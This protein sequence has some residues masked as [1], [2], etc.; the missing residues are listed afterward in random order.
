MEREKTQEDR[1][2]RKGEFS[3]ER[4]HHRGDDN[5]G[6]RHQHRGDLRKDGARRDE[7]RG[8]RRGS[9]SHREGSPRDGIRGPRVP[10]EED[11]A[12]LCEQCAAIVNPAFVFKAKRSFLGRNWKK[13]FA[14]IQK[15]KG[16]KFGKDRS[17]KRSRSPN[18][19]AS[20][21]ANPSQAASPKVQVCDTMAGA[22]NQVSSV[23]CEAST[24]QRMTEAA[25]SLEKMFEE[26]NKNKTNEGKG[27]WYRQGNKGKKGKGYWNQQ[28]RS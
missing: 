10:I 28:W 18:V 26:Q 11:D 25:E 17:P 1:C 7:H 2:Q 27:D 12:V 16:R 21:P 19:G 8:Q 15:D 22:K 3:D 9:P 6:E 24:L 14:R 4:H 13:R 23:A 20:S 5:Q